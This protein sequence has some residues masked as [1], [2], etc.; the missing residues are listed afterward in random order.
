MKNS[1]QTDKDGH[2]LEVSAATFARFA[3]VGKVK[4]SALRPVKDKPTFVPR[5]ET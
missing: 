1:N 5:L 4:E 2:Y 3:L